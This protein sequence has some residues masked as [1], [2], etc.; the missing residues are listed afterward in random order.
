ME[1]ELAEAPA[2]IARMLEAN[3]GACGRL[4]ERLRERPPGVVVTCARGSS[5]H[6]ATYAKYLIETRT[7]VPVA[8]AA[9]SVSS[10]YGRRLNL[11]GQLAIV[12]SQSGRSPDLVSFAEDAV[13]A[14]A[15]LVTVVNDTTS[16]LAGL[17]DICLPLRVGPERSVAATKSYLASLATIVQIVASWSDDED[18]T[19]PLGRL[20]DDLARGLEMDWAAAASLAQ[21]DDLI[22]VGR[23]LGYGIAQE[24]AL[25]FKETCGIHAEAISA[26][27]L[28][29]GP[30]ALIRE[31]FPLLVFS[32]QDETHSG[33]S[34]L[35]QGLRAKGANVWVAEA[36]PPGHGRLP[37]PE[38]LHPACSPIV[39]A[40][41]FY[42]LVHEVALARG[43]DPDSPPHLSKVTETV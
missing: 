4:A 7:G 37:V 43:L 12:I 5:D 31:H 39:M 11:E 16:P 27:E 38:G 25:K 33:V 2:A 20:P 28:R 13:A 24:A 35:V 41:R 18:L 17:G 15:T 10:V 36:G 1:S 22:T 8:S 30:M 32:Q 29:H 3:R 34:A 26:A 21:A 9:P 6:A 14:G 19:T 23:G 40:Q 42:R